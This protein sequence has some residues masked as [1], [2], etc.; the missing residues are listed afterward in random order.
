MSYLNRE[1]KQLSLNFAYFSFEI[2]GTWILGT[3]P[4]SLLIEILYVLVPWVSI[5]NNA[6]SSDLMHALQTW[7]LLDMFIAWTISDIHIL[8]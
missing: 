7:D 4:T 5:E 6:L 1:V 8:K 2:V 3:W